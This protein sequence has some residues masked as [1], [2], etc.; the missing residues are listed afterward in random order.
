[1][2][3]KYCDRVKSC[4]HSW[5]CADDYNPERDDHGCFIQLTNADRIRAMSDNEIADWMDDNMPCRQ[6]CPAKRPMCSDRCYNA[7]LDWLRSPAEG[8]EEKG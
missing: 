1:M 3:S 4:K 6:N 7:W 8:T 2:A 5:W